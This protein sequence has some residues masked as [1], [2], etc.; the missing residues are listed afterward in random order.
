MNRRAAPLI[1]VVLPVL[2]FAATAHAQTR[3]LT[4]TVRV[5]QEDIPFAG[6]EV[7]LLGTDVRVCADQ[8][9]DFTIPVPA[10]GESRL[11]IT[12]VGYMAQ[13]VA[14]QP[15]TQTMEVSL[16]D[17]VFVLDEVIVTGYSTALAARETANSVGRLTA[18]DLNNV[19][20]Q[21]I[22]SAMQG[23]V[24]GAQIMG[25]SGVPGGSYQIIL[26]GINTI[27]GNND[28]LVIVDGVVYNNSSMSTGA[29][30]VTRG[31]RTSESVGSRLGDINPM[32]VERIEV[33]RG[34]SASAMYGS[35]A[36]NG[37]IVITTKRGVAPSPDDGRTGEAIRCFLPGAAL[38]DIR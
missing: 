38:V 1:A 36:G 16:G 25:N 31:M 4:G 15:G 6:A 8:S 17:H 29:D 23:K 9:G 33:L 7:R 22:E 30:V 26:R 18:G 20:A 24:V 19:P 35:K 12:P 13:E 27:L 14:V 28:P 5:G 3:P 21:T 34:P 10:V 11:R 32:D 37:V 2:L